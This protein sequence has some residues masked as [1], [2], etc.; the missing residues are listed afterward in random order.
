VEERKAVYWLA[1]HSRAGGHPVKTGWNAAFAGM[2]LFVRR[3]EWPA[4]NESSVRT[5]RRNAKMLALNAVLLVILAAVLYSCGGGGYGGGGG[6]MAVAPGAF[7]LSSPA[8]MAMGVGA[9]P[10][11]M[12]TASPNTTGYR[13]QVDT[14]DTFSGTLAI[15][16]SVGA[17]TYSFMVSSGTLTAGTL[18]HWRVIAENIYRQ[19]IAGPRS[20][21]PW[22]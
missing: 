10:T 12:W 15:N 5:M 3:K 9:T 8:D 19:A 13:V 6:M 4:S 18:Y 21:T 11:L 2:M 14:M 1:G 20:F 7:S 17:T 16:A 22:R